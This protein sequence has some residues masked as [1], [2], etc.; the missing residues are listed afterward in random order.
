MNLTARHASVLLG[1]LLLGA[2]AHQLTQAE[3][4][5]L[6]LSVLEL[7]LLTAATGACLSRTKP[8]L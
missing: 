6:G 1:A 3:G 7:S 8:L 2:V 5:A 4:A